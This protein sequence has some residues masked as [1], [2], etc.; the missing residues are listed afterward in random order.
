MNATPVT[1]EQNPLVREKAP[2]RQHHGRSERWPTAK[3]RAVS[4]VRTIRGPGETDRNDA[5][6]LARLLKLDQITE[7]TVPY[8]GQEAARDLVRVREDTCG[9]LMRA[10]NRVSKLLLRQR[11]PLQ[12]RKYLDTQGPHGLAL[13]Q[14]FDSPDLQLAYDVAVETVTE[15]LNRRD[16]LDKA[17]TK[18]AYESEYT[19]WS[20]HWNAC[21]GSPRSQRSAWPWRS[22]NGTGSPAAPSAPISALSRA[23]TPPVSTVPKAES[24][25]PETPTPEGC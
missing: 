4:Q 19:P 15:T 21:A 20:G 9:D 23:K 2:F 25:K 22:A 8:P 11:P 3:P 13:S 16:H 6:H 24:R 14:R 10:R 5:L 17:I 12:R 1:L 7:V 18:I